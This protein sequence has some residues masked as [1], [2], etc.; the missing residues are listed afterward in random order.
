MS[1]TK[2]KGMKKLNQILLYIVLCVCIFN[3]RTIQARDAYVPT[4]GDVRIP[5][6]LVE[7][8]DNT[9][10]L[11]NPVEAINQ[12]FNTTGGTNPSAK[13]SVHTSY[14][15]TSLGQLNLQYDIYGP[16]KLSREM[17]YYGGNIGNNSDKN[18][19]ALVIEAANLAEAAGVDFAQYDNDGDGNIDN[20]SIIT[21]GHNEAEGASADHIWPHYSTIYSYTVI[22]G[23]RLLGYLMT[24][25]LCG[26]SGNIQ[27]G[28]GTYCH[29]FGHG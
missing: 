8:Q 10:T 20:V 13:G 7:F 16:Y 18:A 4:T 22:S 3:V 12:L 5:I 11:T 24:S 27:S 29:E 28:I 9:F 23:K 26:S 17:S 15:E 19:T 1:N 6:I 2:K 25:E 14:Y 21:A